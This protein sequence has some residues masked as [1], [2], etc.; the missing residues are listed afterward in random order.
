M[1]S[2]FRS[3][4]RL[5]LAAAMIWLAPGIASSQTSQGAPNHVVAQ[6]AVSSLLDARAHLDVSDTELGVALQTLSYRARVPL[7]FSRSV[8]PRGHRVTCDCSRAT[9]ALAL[10]R[11]LA[12]TSL[13][14]AEVAG[15][16]LIEADPNGHGVV[17]IGRSQTMPAPLDVEMRVLE[18]RFEIPL[19]RWRQAV[20][21]GRVTSEGAP[22]A[23]ADVRVLRTE[24]RT[25]TREDGRY[26]IPGV[27]A[28]THTVQV[29]GLGFR[30]QTATVTVPDGGTVTLDFE[31]AP[32]AIG[33]DEVVVTAT[34]ERRRVEIGNVV[35][36]IQADSLIAA[37]PVNTITDLITAR[38][39][40]AQIVGIDGLTGTSPSIRIRG[41]NSVSLSSAPLIIVD[42]VRVNNQST[43]GQAT[44]D[45]RAGFGQWGGRLN[46]LSPAEIE[47]IEI[48]KGPSAATLYGTDAANGVIVITTKRGTTGPPMWTAFAEVGALRPAAQ[49][50]D[51]YHSWGSDAQGNTRHCRLMDSVSGACAI[52][53]LT[54]FNPL[55]DRATSPIGTGHRHQLGAQVRGGADRFTYFFAGSHEKETGY[56]RLPRAEQERLMAERGTTS[57][58]DEQI[59]PNWSEKLS[60]RMNSGGVFGNAHLTV[61][62]GLVVGNNQVPSPGSITFPGEF[63]RG[64]NDPATFGGWRDG[65]RPGETFSVRNTENFTRYTGSLAG[66]WRPRGWLELRS[67]AGLDLTNAGLDALQRTDEGPVLSTFRQGRRQNTR[68]TTA[69]YSLD[70]GAAASFQL[71]PAV[72]SRTS[73]G[74]QYN[75]RT[76]GITSVVGNVLPS[77]SETIRGASLLSAF[78][79]NNQTIVAGAYLEEMVG[80]NDRLFLSGAVRFDGGSSFGQD[81]T[82]AVYPKASA[83]WLALDRGTDGRINTLR[84]RGA[85]G[86]SGV[87]PGATDALSL[88][89]IFTA[90]V[91][92]ANRAAARPGTIGNP[93]LRPER[94]SEIEAGVDGTLLAG[95]LTIEATYYNRV[96]R[97]ALIQRPLSP[98]VG[99]ASRW[100]NIGSVRNSGV[101]GMIA[102]Q[103]VQMPRFSWDVGLNGSIN[104]N[105][106]EQLGLG[107]EAIGSLNYRHVEGFPLFG[108]WAIPI[109]GF[110]D[111]NGNGII[112]PSE[113]T[114]GD[115]LTFLGPSIAPRQ[116]TLST[117][118][119]LFNN[120]LRIASLFDRRSGFAHVNANEINRCSPNISNCRAVNDPATPLHEQARIVSF[121]H[122]NF[123]GTW[124]GF[125]ED[126]SFTRWRE[127]AVSLNLPVELAGRIGARG[128]V[129]ALAGRNLKLW[130][131]YSGKDPEVGTNPGLAGIEG[132]S[133][134]PTV[135]QT[136]YVT[137]RITLEL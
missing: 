4:I 130:T 32:T 87:Q 102:L 48:S 12:G 101:E 131:T 132:Y 57:I 19:Y 40:G 60:L 7:L 71:R 73:V 126:G 120:R 67:V 28:G 99:V 92:G 104:R 113:V 58:P 75:R 31:L 16:I 84:V 108:R 3:R 121:F 63:G 64:Y 106:L 65:R 105:R 97:D 81:F 70:I 103:A 137:F 88:Y 82:T 135:P 23:G 124:A 36:R 6:N 107:V 5:S 118:V 49:F 11:M 111:A 2:V 56:F 13:R 8:L 46:D 37:A 35:G 83:S 115:S 22:V 78:E 20:L 14:F 80:F 86:A 68:S 122:T 89:D 15:Q 93:D 72:N 123:G 33:L 85:Y 1:E 18:P 62:S 53:S 17:Q 77:G 116:L 79:Q 42:G 119:N 50:L 34:G 96:S 133:D 114:Y 52:D 91:G 24:R 43:I 134:N 10:E 110:I 55:H 21:T 112:E 94:Q 66:G 69:L 95:R 117:G 127:L 45:P 26:L 74:F 41:I 90:Y 27:P 38:V 39:A 54:V 128:A 44:T 51:N 29:S 47:S 98:D 76:D 9:V 136:R 100:E 61:S 59:R 25:L 129:V 109:I 30:R 125:L